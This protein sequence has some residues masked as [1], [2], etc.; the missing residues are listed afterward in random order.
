[1]H[2]CS[3]CGGCSGSCGG[4]GGCAKSLSLT[5][6]EITFLEKLG[7]IPFLPV[8][9][10]TGDLIPIYREEEEKD[11]EYYSLLLQCLEKKNLVSLDYDLPLRGCNA[12]WYLACPVQGS[13]TLTR[14]GQ[15]VLELLEYQGVEE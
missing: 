2:D 14:R 15:Q 3:S 4:C 11:G 7:Q 8:G 1:M 12:G 13:L 6:D 9:R 10:K 5:K